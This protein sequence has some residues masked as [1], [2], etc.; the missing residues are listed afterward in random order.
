MVG[1]ISAGNKVTLKPSEVTTET[2]KVIVE[3]FS[4]EKYKITS[5]LLLVVL[6]KRQV[7]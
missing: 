6:K 2:E 7:F 4:S 5:R 3:M 1:A